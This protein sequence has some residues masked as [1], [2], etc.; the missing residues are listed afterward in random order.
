MWV[1]FWVF[2]EKGTLIKGHIKEGQPSAVQGGNS[3]RAERAENTGHNNQLPHNYSPV[4][5]KKKLQHTPNPTLNLNLLT[6]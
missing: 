2:F 1:F 4:K 5:L 6:T 3:P